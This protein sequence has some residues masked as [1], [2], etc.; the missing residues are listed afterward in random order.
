[1]QPGGVIGPRD[2]STFRVLWAL[3]ARGLPVT[4]GAAR[5]GIVDV[6]DCAMG[7]VLALEKGRVGECYHL[8]DENLSLPDLVHRAIDASGVQGST[9]V[10]PDW[11]IGLN[12]AFMSLVERVIP[13]PDVMSS[14]ALRGMKASLTLIVETQKARTELGWTPRPMAEALREILADELM[15]R[16][17]KLPPQL[18]G[19]RPH[20]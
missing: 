11:L 12:A 9:L 2:H 13:V 1:V 7:H 4:M 3:L 10:F 14:D 5:Y 17:K 15:L 20:A 16:G 8:V 6:E 19:V 18:E